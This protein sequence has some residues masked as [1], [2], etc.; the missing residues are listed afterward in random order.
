MKKQ[1]SCEVP[2]NDNNRVGFKQENHR[3][4]NPLGLHKPEYYD[5]SV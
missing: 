3:M 5:Y 4:T 2:Q 1:Q